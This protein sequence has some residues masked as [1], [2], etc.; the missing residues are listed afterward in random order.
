[1]PRLYETDLDVALRTELRLLLG[2]SL[3]CCTS[4]IRK[5]DENPP[6]LSVFD[7]A[8]ALAGTRGCASIGDIV[9]VACFEEHFG[10]FRFPGHEQ[11]TPVADL[12]VIV[13]LVMVL[14]GNMSRHTRTNV[15]KLLARFAADD[16]TLGIACEPSAS[17]SA[18]GALK[19]PGKSYSKPLRTQLRRLALCLC[20]KCVRG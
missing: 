8:K 5:T 10:D 15:A 16:L 14:P 20:S 18:E 13:D 17:V 4:R 12:A 9:M 1:M 7:V 6:R 2:D 19:M 11:D 3:E